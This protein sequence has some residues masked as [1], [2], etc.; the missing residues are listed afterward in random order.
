MMT[1]SDRQTIVTE[2]YDRWAEQYA[3]LA[4]HAPYVRAYRRHA[5]D[6]LELSP[7][8]TVVDMG[9]G[10]GVNFDLLSSEIGPE[11]RVIGIDIAPGML[12]QAREGAAPSVSVIRGDATRP[13]FAAG[14]DGILATF[15]VTLFDDA[16]DVVE[17]WWEL[18]EPGGRL[19]LVNLGPGRGPFAPCI[20]PFLRIGLKL[21]TPTADQL[22][23]DLVELLRGRV[24]DAHGRLTELADHVVYDDMDGVLRLAVGTKSVDAG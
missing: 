5:V 21:S 1:T 13:P 2:F 20:N 18:L 16:G 10:P 24:T 12:T 14:V 15:V 7:G 3:P 11:G 6:R 23:E 4:Q 8:D 22:D 17:G 9:C 19:A